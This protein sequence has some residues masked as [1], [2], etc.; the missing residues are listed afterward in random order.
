MDIIGYLMK[1]IQIICLFLVV[2][3]VKAQGYKITNEQSLNYYLN[4]KIDSAKLYISYFKDSEQIKDIIEK[5]I[6]AKAVKKIAI[7]WDKSWEYPHKV[8]PFISF[9]LEAY[10]SLFSLSISFLDADSLDIKTLETAP[11]LTTL[12]LEINNKNVEE[13]FMAISKLKGL[14]YITFSSSYFDSLYFPHPPLKKVFILYL[15][16]SFTQIIPFD[17]SYSSVRFLHIGSSRKIDFI[18]PE[19]IQSYNQPKF[20]EARLDYDVD[21]ITLSY[22]KKAFPKVHYNNY[23]HETL[24]C[25]CYDYRYL[26]GRFRKEIKKKSRKPIKTMFY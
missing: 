4:N 16:G 5:N 9:N 6:N 14:N 18:H 3:N 12:A 10:D 8:L 13:T 2:S 19:I 24:Y 23:V 25:E 26:N 11:Q 15:R 21:R 17:T 7:N 22:L 1:V 20:V